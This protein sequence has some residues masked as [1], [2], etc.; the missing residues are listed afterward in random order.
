MLGSRNSIRRN[1]A[2]TNKSK[3]STS[4]ASDMFRDSLAI[5]INELYGITSR[6]EAETVV[7]EVKQ[8][9]DTIA[10]L[11]AQYLHPLQAM[12]DVKDQIKLLEDETNRAY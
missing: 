12:I 9:N 6:A 3:N 1:E 8:I 2:S 5:Q 7:R 10:R 11:S 4:Q